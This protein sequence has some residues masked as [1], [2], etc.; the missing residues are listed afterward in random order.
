MTPEASSTHARPSADRAAT[1]PRVSPVGDPHAAHRA[2]SL[3][4]A[5]RVPLVAGLALRLALAP[6]TST[7]Y[8][9]DVWY[10]EAL[11]GL[12]GEPLYARPGFGYPP[13]WGAFLHA[14]GAL[15]HL[16]G[17]GPSA[18][19]SP[20]VT[21]AGLSAQLPAVGSPVVTTWGF[22]LAFKAILI[23]FDLGTGWLLWRVALRLWGDGR[24]A[25]WAFVLWW[26]SPLVIFESAV[27]G[28]FDTMV[29]FF[30]LGAVAARL[31]RRP[32]LCGAALALG[33]LTKVVP[34][35]LVPLLVAATV[36]PW[37]GE[38]PR[39][40]SFDLGR[41]VAGAAA[42]AFVVVLPS[43]A[44]GEFTAM[45]HAASNGRGGPAGVGGIGWWGV[46]NIGAA[47]GL[48]QWGNAH[49]NGYGVVAEVAD[50]AVALLAALWWLRPGRRRGPAGLLLAG[51]VVM[52]VPVLLQGRAQ[53]QYLVWSLP[54]LA[55]LG[56]ASPLARGGLWVTGAAGAAFELGGLGLFG[57]FTPLALATGVPSLASVVAHAHALYATPGLVAQSEG[58]DVEV[59]A[60]V[61]L[62][63]ASVVTWVAVVAQVTGRPAALAAP[64]AATSSAYR[65]RPAAP[66]AMAGAGAAVAVALLANV[67]FAASP[68]TS[69][70]AQRAGPDHVAVSV[71]RA[72]APVRFAAFFSSAAPALPRL[73][74]YEDPRYPLSGSS[75]TDVADFAD[76][77]RADLDRSPAAASVTTID[78]EGLAKVLS[79]LRDAPHS[80]V[81][82]GTGTLPATVWAS[83]TNLVQPWLRA[84]G[85]LVWAGSTPG[86][87]SVVP[88]SQIF[89]APA[90]EVPL[91]G[92]PAPAPT[93]FGC[94]TEGP[95]LKVVKGAVLYPGMSMAGG[96]GSTAVLGIPFALPGTTPGSGGCVASRPGK[97]ASAL[98]IQY[99]DADSAPTLAQ[100]RRIGGRVLGSLTGPA[101]DPRS[102]SSVSWLPAG[103]GG[104][105]LFGGKLVP[106]VVASDAAQLLLS[107]AL[108]ATS[109]PQAVTVAP[110]ARRNLALGRGAGRI[111]VAAFDASLEGR[112]FARFTLGR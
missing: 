23:G 8:D 10:R 35:F 85:T 104:T 111:V 12:L 33:I 86:L 53:P 81:V 49:A 42:T 5:C 45:V 4:A 37:P 72:P 52:T 61:V 95:A 59:A 83:T 97:V 31:E 32:G 48:R 14:L 39:R 91:K 17:L 18:L 55:L 109:P 110:G 19:G 63:L 40:R 108:E 1:A 60:W 78:A 9:V 22:T 62:L 44:H 101:T 16:V 88:G 24:R 28:T 84:G 47:S 107:G 102:R 98:E 20:S 105:V 103:R 79:D 99:L 6:F 21:L 87:F 80:A 56:S 65:A 69:A 90:I 13:V 30:V 74:L 36:V 73:Y 82:A 54:L 89:A 11:H 58:G 76:D 26:L 46:T 38:Q 15:A 68:A 112:Y 75:S 77:L 27:H 100:L 50:L 2:T 29:A 25:R 94:R 66:T 96:I 3:W 64:G 57:F 41:L 70:T 43:L 67:A 71:R 93:A 34:V 7:P 106:S 51:A 92:R